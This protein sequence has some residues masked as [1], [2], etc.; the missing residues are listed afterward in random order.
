MDIRKEFV[1]FYM[2]LMGTAATL[3]PAVSKDVMQLGPKLSQQQKIQ[4]CCPITNR[5][6]QA[7]FIAIRIDK[8]P[9][10]DGFNATF[11]KHA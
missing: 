11:F 10:I 1:D 2:S 3:L 6:T 8:S 9:D 4:L 5:E 7:G